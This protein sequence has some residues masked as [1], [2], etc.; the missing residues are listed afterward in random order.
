MLLSLSVNDWHEAT[1]L[2][3]DIVLLIGAIGAAI[4]FR[5][6]NVL[7]F[8]W[9]S[10]L[11]CTHYELP[12]SS[13]IF[14]ADYVINNT[15]QRPLKLK[16]VTLRL[17]GARKDGALLMPDEDRTYATR[18]FEIRQ[19]C[20]ERTFPN[21]AGRADDLSVSGPTRESGRSRFRPL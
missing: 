12:D 4:K 6:F 15:G 16:N 14:T 2:L 18:V 8:R 5:L 1:G 21:R 13:I 20:I 17:T 9:R 10:E 7:G 11:T 19:S 3:V